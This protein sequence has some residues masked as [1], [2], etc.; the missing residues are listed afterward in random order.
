[1]VVPLIFL[2]LFPVLGSIIPCFASSLVSDFHVLLT[3]KQG[4]KF[5]E[6]ALSSWN[7]SSS[8]TSVCSSWVGIRC[9]R[10]RVVAVDLTDL[11]L[12]GSV[13]PI[14][15][16]LD[17]LSDLSLA[18]NNL[19]GSIELAN[20]GSL[21]SLNISD[22]QF[23]GG[24]DWN[25]SSIANLEVFDV[26]DNNLTAPLPLGILNLSKLRYLD[27]GGNFFYGKVPP[28]Y[29]NLVS[30]EYLSLSG[31]DLHGEIPGE[32]GNLTNLREIYLGYYNVFEGGIPKEFG[33]LVNLVHMDLSS[34]ELDG[35]IPHELGNLKS[36]DTLYLH[37]NLLSGSIPRQLGNLTS[38]LYFDL[39][40]NA[41]TGE[42]PSEFSNLRQLKLFNLFMNRLHGSIPDY[43]ADLPDLDTLGLWMNNFTGIIPQK[44]GQNRKLQLLDLSSNKLTGKIPP[45]L[46]SSNQLRILI[47]LKNFLFG[48]IPSGLGTCC[49]LT[50]LR[51][52]QNYLNGSIPNGLIYLPLLS[53]AE[54]QDNYLSGTLSEN[55]NSSSQP[56]LLGQLI[57]SNNLLSGKIPYSISN[58]SSLQIFSLSGNQLSGPIP[59]SIGQLHQVLNL[60][61]SRNSLSGEIPPEIGNCFHLTYLDMSQNNLSGSIPSEISSIHILNYIN[62][63]RNHL[64][65]SIPKSLAT[66]KSLTTADFSFNDLSGKLPEAGQFA[67]FNASSFA[68]NPQLCGSLLNNP[69]NFTSIT[70]SPGNPRA[71]FKLIFA[72]GLLICSLVFAAAAIMKAKSFKRK[73]PESWKMTAFQKVEFTMSDVLECVKDGNVIGRGGAGIVYH[74]KMPNGVEI[75]VKK[76]LGFGFGLAPNSTHDDH[77]FRAEIQTLGNI[78]HRN[79]VRLLAFCSNKETNLLVYE[80]MRNGS[81]GEALH[82]NNKKGGLF[83][84]WN[85]RY[86][87]AI[88]AA[89]GLCYLHHDCSP[90]ILHR[91]VKSNNILLN[92]SFEAHVADF[93][94][95]KFLIDGGGASQCMSAIAGSYGY[96]APEYAYTLRVDEKS[97]V[98]SFGV[99][100]L[101]LLTGRRPVGEFG[102]GIDIVQWSKKVTNCR[103]QDAADIVDPRLAISVPKDEAM[104]LFFIAMHCVQ[105]NSVERP[106]MREVVQMLSEFPRAHSPDSSSSLIP[107]QQFDNK[108]NDSKCPPKFKQ[109]ILV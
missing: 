51:L 100:L 43:V 5:S 75:A 62:M 28:L 24:L 69:C 27:L 13:S 18:G 35:Q 72:L 7:S 38:L 60:D 45:N 99:V 77:G 20:L 6:P 103:K 102:E 23:S 95:A 104:H 34:C 47:L 74:G 59:P 109:H 10:G 37:I 33:K 3:L 46:C 52:G 22:N 55:A 92:S 61:L 16:G 106:T 82:V 71:D 26:Y 56:A 68:G 84:S 70:D 17:R 31:N 78:R 67:F 50:R 41:L 64:N 4:F 11:S 66:M 32:L 89:K 107:S 48:P 15:S 58:F 73:G 63:S 88:E 91:D 12:S 49:S 1:M 19:S 21:R 81:L 65:Q 25:F 108:Q 57:L 30:L 97:D 101:E 40:N 54:L 39:S 36:L 93:G 83:L 8:P 44:L 53:L 76:L 2:S 85:L 42:I 87:I 80:Y 29:G 96:I 79:I 86:K 9:S 94:L 98:Y 14:I 105:E 90:L